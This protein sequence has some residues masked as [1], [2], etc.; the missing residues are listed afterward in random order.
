VTPGH[1]SPLGSPLS[2][3][4]RRAVSSESSAKGEADAPHDPQ[5]ILNELEESGLFEG[6]EQLLLQ[7]RLLAAEGVHPLEALQ[8]NRQEEPLDPMLQSFDL[9]GVAR[10]IKDHKCQNIV[11]LCGAG[12][13]T[14]A[15]IPDFRT[16]GSGLYD[17]LQRF[18][19]TEP[20]TI[21]DLRFFQREPGPFYEL[22]RELWPGTYQP[23]ISHHFIRLLERKGLLRRC[24]TQNI[25]SLE[26]Q[27][28]ISPEKIVAAHGNMDEAHVVGTQKV[29]DIEEVRRAIFSGEDGWRELAAVHG[30]LVK[31]RIVMF[32]EDLPDRFWD[33]QEEDLQKCDLLIVL[34]T[35]LVVEPFASLVGKAS[36][37]A[38][39]LLI[40]R[41]PAGTCDKLLFGFRF[42]LP[43]IA[44]WR[45]VWFE[46]NCDD[47]CLALAQ[48]L[49]WQDELHQ[50]Q[51]KE[52]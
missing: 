34:G 49:G 25:D 24:Y 36:S 19:L 31:P 44:N 22:C 51:A 21:F 28:G 45:D 38:P 3:I 8:R 17:N 41:E 47:G 30:G 46:G 1:I 11:V 50:M 33:L 4:T 16:P 52:K 32:G 12:M 6:E 9:A 2:S 48:E 14:S 18:N 10:Y 39:R 20:E 42:H 23:T 35:S 15:G 43:K 26:R 37:T 5:E 7:L 40:N 13:S 27:A 29:V